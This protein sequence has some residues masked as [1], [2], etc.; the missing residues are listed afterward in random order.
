M[1]KAGIASVLASLLLGFGQLE[2]N[3]VVGC[4]YV[5]DTNDAWVYSHLFQIL[6]KYRRLLWQALYNT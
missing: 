6:V 3:N 1:S 4:D 5:W 2:E